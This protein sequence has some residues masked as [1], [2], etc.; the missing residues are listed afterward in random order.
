[1]SAVEAGLDAELVFIGRRSSSKD[2][3]N[4]RVG[5]AI[6]R[7]YPIVWIEDASDHQVL[8][9]VNNSSVFLSF[10]I[11]GYGIPVLEAIRV[12][13]PVFFDGIQPA[14]ELM[15]G[16]GAQHVESTTSDQMTALLLHAEEHLETARRHL[17]PIS[18]PTWQN[19]TD[20]VVQSL[21]AS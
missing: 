21:L 12:G 4:R 10:G 19:F 6:A 5:D 18:V 3:I 17:D 15:R 20:G 1:M 9:A 13:T 16:R 7:G 14:A 11:E 8:E 2:I